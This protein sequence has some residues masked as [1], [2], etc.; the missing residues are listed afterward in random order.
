MDKKQLSLC[1]PICGGTNVQVLAWIDANTNLFCADV[2]SH[3]DA[4]NTW[5]E[6]CQ[7]HTGLITIEEFLH[8]KNK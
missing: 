5:C 8:N 4:E 1:C 6:D 3:I 2:D 7:E